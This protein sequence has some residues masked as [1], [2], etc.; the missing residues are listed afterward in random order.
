M[1]DNARNRIDRHRHSRPPT[2]S[3]RRRRALLALVALLACVVAAVVVSTLRDRPSAAADDPQAARTA[4]MITSPPA[5]TPAPVTPDTAPTSAVPGTFADA[6]ARLG[7]PLDPHTGW[8]VAQGL[9]V[10]L[11]Q[12][13]YDRFRLAEGVERLFPS[14]SDEQAHAFVAMVA[15]AVCH[16]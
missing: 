1:A 14:V 10:R 11:G 9:C 3:E 13:Q 8:V 15:T 12:P 4:A 6:M 5:T 16:R 2:L 7:V